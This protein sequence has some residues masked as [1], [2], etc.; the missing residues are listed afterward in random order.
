M[1]HLK[2]SWILAGLLA[3][4]SVMM[5][6]ERGKTSAGRDFYQVWLM[7]FAKN[8]FP[9]RTDGELGIGNLYRVE[10]RAAVGQLMTAMVTYEGFPH[11]Q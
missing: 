11:Q 4:G 10:D 1:A 9:Q 5:A 7:L 8:N 2:A 3:A 6:V